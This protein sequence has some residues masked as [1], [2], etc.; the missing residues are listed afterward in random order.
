[1]RDAAKL[2]AEAAAPTPP[3][4]A[5]SVGKA[6]DVHGCLITPPPRP[7]PKAVAYS[8]SKPP[9]P[10]STAQGQSTEVRQPLEAACAS[11]VNGGDEDSAS[12]DSDIECDKRRF[13][14]QVVWCDQR[15]FKE[16]HGE[17]KTQ[18]EAATQMPVKAHKTAEKCMR[19]L[20]KKKRAALERCQA[21][22]PSV[23]L[24]SWANAPTLVPY[25]CEVCQE[26]AKVVVL[27][28]LCGVKGCDS[29]SRWSR[30][31]PLVESIA[32]SQDEAVAMVAKAVLALQLS[33]ASKS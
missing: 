28:D 33:A 4:K 16:A 30:H 11:T 23:F 29:A 32:V 17:L 2:A 14:C 8:P 22:S 31:F 10:L 27:C 18:L 20:Q 3:R 6:A 26:S 25:L 19:L 9:D 21:I 15:A 7:K 1:M 12:S 13:Y 24:V 5:A